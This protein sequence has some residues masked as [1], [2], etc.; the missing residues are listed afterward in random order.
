MAMLLQLLAHLAL[1]VLLQLLVHLLHLALQS[2]HQLKLIAKRLP[3]GGRFLLVFTRKR[4]AFFGGLFLLA[5]RILFVC[6][7]ARK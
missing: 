7:C 4:L 1:L 3:V 2:H 5:L 6:I